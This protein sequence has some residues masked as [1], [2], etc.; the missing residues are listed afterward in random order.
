MYAALGQSALVA[1]HHRGEGDD[2]G[3]QAIHSGKNPWRITMPGAQDCTSKSS[4]KKLSRP[5]DNS[6][7]VE[8]WICQIGSWK[9]RTSDKKDR[10]RQKFGN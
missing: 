2:Q 3:E 5:F 6:A 7:V 4:F 9:Y 8:V 10:A 1:V